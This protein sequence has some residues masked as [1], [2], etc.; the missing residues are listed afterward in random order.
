MCTM[1]TIGGGTN[2]DVIIEQKVER[3]ENQAMEARHKRD[4]QKKKKFF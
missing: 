1:N 2:C 3:C 4:L